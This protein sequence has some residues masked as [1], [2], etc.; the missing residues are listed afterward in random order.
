MCVCVC[1]CV[2]VHIHEGH[3]VNKGRFFWKKEKIINIP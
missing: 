3:S 1:V 2:C